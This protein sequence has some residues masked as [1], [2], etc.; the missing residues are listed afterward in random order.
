MA[1]GSMLLTIQ[2]KTFW[3][4][5]NK[6]TSNRCG[7]ARV[8]ARTCGRVRVCSGS[9]IVAPALTNTTTRGVS[10]HSSQQVAPTKFQEEEEQQ[11]K[12][13]VFEFMECVLFL[14]F[15]SRRSQHNKQGWVQSLLS[16]STFF[17]NS[18]G[19]VAN[20]IEYFFSECFKFKHPV[21]SSV[22]IS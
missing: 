4:A 13:D 20:N 22:S 14:A 6:R 21:N 17:S 2:E 9:G 19:F 1:E 15:L 3:V 12:K 18:S 7:T 8:A 16:S 11:G 10:S 5:E